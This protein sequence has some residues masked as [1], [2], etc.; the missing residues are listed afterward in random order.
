MSPLESG[1]TSSCLS[2]S[3]LWYRSLYLRTKVASLRKYHADKNLHLF[4]ADAESLQGKKNLTILTRTDICMDKAIHSIHP[5]IIVSL[6]GG[7]RNIPVSLILFV[8]EILA[9]HTEQF[10]N[11]RNTNQGCPFTYQSQESHSSVVEDM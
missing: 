6:I 5:W 7:S 11:R 1:R 9:V 4:A 2:S 10:W 3:C 8:L